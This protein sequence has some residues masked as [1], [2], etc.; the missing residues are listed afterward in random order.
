ML[1]DRL[2]TERMSSGNSGHDR[3]HAVQPAR[4]ANRSGPKQRVLLDY[5]H[6]KNAE[7]GG[8]RV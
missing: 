4:T 2:L 5:R 3:K 8:R 1:L 6:G 7:R